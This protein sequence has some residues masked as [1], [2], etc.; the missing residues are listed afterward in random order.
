[1]PKHVSY[2]KLK[3]DEFVDEIIIK[4]VPRYK[5]SDMSGDEWRTSASVILKRKGLTVFNRSFATMSAATA[6]LPGMFIEVTE[7]IPDEFYFKWNKGPR[8][9]ECMQ[10]GCNHLATHEFR[11]NAHYTNDATKIEIDENEEHRWRFC[12]V[13]A[14]RGDAA[15]EDSDANIELIT[16][17][18]AT[19]GHIPLDDISP[20]QTIYI[21]LDEDSESD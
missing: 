9:T 14:R 5:T 2:R 19:I 13:H 1:M 20:A 12:A 3:S 18:P 4:Q 11:I 21:D 6:F 15:Y 10:P 7:M 8:Q 17:N 16:G